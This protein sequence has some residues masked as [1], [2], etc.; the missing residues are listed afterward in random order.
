MH[1]TRIIK[2]KLPLIHFIFVDMEKFMK[3]PHRTKVTPIINH[4]SK[5]G[6]KV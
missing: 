5:D 4:P 2:K 1:E 3:N 6:L